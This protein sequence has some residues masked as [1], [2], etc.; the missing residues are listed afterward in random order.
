MQ[1][2]R[3]RQVAGS[4]EFRGL[5]ISEADLTSLLDRP[6]GAP[7]WSTAPELVELEARLQWMGAAIE[8]R[9]EAS[10]AQGVPLRLET[11]AQRHELDRLDLDLLV[12]GLAPELDVRYER[13]FAYLQDDVTRKRPSVDLALSLLCPSTAAR[14]AARVRFT[15][16]ARLL[17]HSL[18]RLYTDAPQLQPPLLQLYFKVDNRIVEY[19][20]GGDEI[21]ERLRPNARALPSSTTLADVL[22]PPALKARL[23]ALLDVR[24]PPVLYLQGESGVGRKTLAGALCQ[25][26]GQRLLVLHGSALAS[27]ADEAAT[28]LA[29]ALRETR[30]LDCAL[31]IDGFDKL[32]GAETKVLRTDLL[33]TIG[34]EKG[35]VFLSGEC[36]YQPEVG[37]FE[38]SFVRVELPAP[39]IAERT[40][41]WRRSLPASMPLAEGVEPDAQAANHRQTGRQIRDATPTAGSQAR[42]RDPAAPRV[43][44]ADLSDACRRHSQPR[45][46]SLARKIP[47]LARW[48]DLVLTEDRM[49]RLGEIA[50]RAR[51]RS[52]VFDTW[53]FDRKLP[54]GKGLSVLF[55]GPPGTG[56][57]L[58]ASVLANELGLDL[59]QI[60]LS[61]VVSKYIGETEK[62]L[63]RIFD[64][65]ESTR[66]VLFFDEADALFGKRTE[67]KDAHDRYANIETSYLLQRVEAYEGMVILASNLARNMDEAFTRRIQFILEFVNP[68]RRERLRIWQE[69]FPE[70]VPLEP[71]LDLAF[72]AKRFELAGGFIRNIALAAAFLAASDGRRVSREHLLRA[73]RREY[74]KMGKMVDESMF[75]V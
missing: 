6:P 43:T 45:L 52:V 57:T 1:A 32:L 67:V 27:A 49:R 26:R 61:S 5:V 14:L 3:A 29:L 58:A 8:R 11:L 23:A 40:E 31:L 63:A 24:P 13:L 19:L 37:D 44:M 55:T 10:I 42:L 65:A 74:Q 71:D 66:A 50:A 75:V 30:L 33:R 36:P 47:T 22:L 54:T 72:M 60:D 25:A 7:H 73:T 2:I 59:Y 53:G 68:D 20:L 38:R 17:R 21:D 34:A 4:D 51:H 15:A 62:Q 16:S 35:V 70:N 64:E 18:L 28:L 41:L 46:G 48:E 39:G 12:I 56:K 9:R 69:I